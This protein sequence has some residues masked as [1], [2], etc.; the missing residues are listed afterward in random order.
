MRKALA[1]TVALAMSL[2]VASG[3]VGSTLSQMR[4]VGAA[5]KRQASAPVQVARDVAP[6]APAA[7]GRTQSV[8]AESGLSLNVAGAA[9]PQNV[10]A[11]NVPPQPDM[12]ATREAA[13]SGIRAKAENSPDTPPNVFDVKRPQVGQMTA[14]EQAQF[15]A[16]LEAAGAANG[17]PPETAN[18]EVDPVNWLKKKN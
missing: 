3:C 11:T 1:R 17:T 15:K 14:A 4:G 5:P 10:A 2:V 8:A 7:L 13:V 16:E 6:E 12:G 9:P 18:A